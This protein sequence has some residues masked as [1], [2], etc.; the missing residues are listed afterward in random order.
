VEIGVTGTDRLGRRCLDPWPFKADAV[1]VRC[2][3][4]RLTDRAQSADEMRD[5]L[6]SAPWETIE[7]ELVAAASR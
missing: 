5:A 2:E 3:G 4:Q 7:F 6:A 1:T